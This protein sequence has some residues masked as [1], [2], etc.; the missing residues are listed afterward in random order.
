ME[1]SSIFSTGKY[2]EIESSIVDLVNAQSGILSARTAPSTRAAG[3]AIQS[4]LSEHFEGILGDLCVEYQASFP[5]R[6]MADLAFTDCDGF[7]YAVDV[8]SHRIGTSF[9]R[10]NLTSIERISRFYEGDKNYFVILMVKYEV[11]GTQLRAREALFVPI[12]F[13]SWNCLAIGAL[14]WGQIQIVSAG[15]IDVDTG[16]SRQGWMLQLCDKALAFY[17]K[18]IAKIERRI[19]HFQ[20]MRSRWDSESH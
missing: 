3:D 5:R 12:E 7:Y 14:G 15:S 2:K 6:A 11:E 18:E 9:N 8:K 17:P 13:L 10:P 19:R 16:S 1:V 4:I 20:R